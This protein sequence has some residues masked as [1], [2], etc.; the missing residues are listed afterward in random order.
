M[1]LIYFYDIIPIL[2]ACIAFSLLAMAHKVFVPSK[3]SSFLQFK[4][5]EDVNKTIKSTVIRIIYLIIGTYIL[6]KKMGLSG[7]QIGIGIFIA[8]F[9]NVW[10]AIIQNQLL[11]VRNRMVDINGIYSLYNNFYIS[12]DYDNKIVYT[13]I[14]RK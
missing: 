8:C 2:I 1:V 13:N 9:L 3:Y 5:D 4:E 7:K 11:K 12:R 10:P 14:R 6:N